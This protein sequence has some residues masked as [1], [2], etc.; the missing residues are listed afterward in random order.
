MLTIFNKTIFSTNRKN[1]YENY[2]VKKTADFI[3]QNVLNNSCFRKNVYC[4]V[5]RFQSYKNFNYKY[6]VK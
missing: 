6:L 2:I 4:A 1:M 5:S 3:L